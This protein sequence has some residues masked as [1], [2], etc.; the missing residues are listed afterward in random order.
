MHI[1]LASMCMS[2][3]YI[4]DPATMAEIYAAWNAV[5]FGRDLGIRNV[6]ME[7]DALKIVHSF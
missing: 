3:L 2:I 1:A 6:I 4:I 7:G 5:F